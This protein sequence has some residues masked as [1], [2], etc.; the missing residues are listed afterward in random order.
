M[1]ATITTDAHLV[2]SV[3]FNS[4]NHSTDCT[5]CPPVHLFSDFIEMV[6]LGTVISIGTPANIYILIKLIRELRQTPKDSVRAGFLL[7]KINLNISDLFILIV[8][9]L[10]KLTW[11]A[12]YAWYAFA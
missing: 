2:D 9:A 7:M 1:A 3:S 12:T 11:L 10:G 8:L 6:Y 4:T 5:H